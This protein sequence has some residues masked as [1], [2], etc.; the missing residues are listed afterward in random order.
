MT[1]YAGRQGPSAVASHYNEMEFV[2]SQL[3]GKVGTMGFV[4]VVAV[5]PAGTGSMIGGTVDVQPMVHQVDGQGAPTPHGTIH[6][7]T[8]F[9]LQSGSNAV[10]MDPVKGDIGMAIIASR[11]SSSVKSSGAPSPPASRRQFDWSDG[12][13]V[14]GVLNGAPTQFI[15]FLTSGI[16]VKTTGTFEVDAAAAQ[17]NCPITATGDVTGSGISLDNHVHTGVESGTSTTGKPVG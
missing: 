10:L 11:D 14:G 13:Y 15:Q 16:K 2:F 17:F 3:I 6:S 8:Y 9:R 4:Q 1:G 5:T 7:L 12:V